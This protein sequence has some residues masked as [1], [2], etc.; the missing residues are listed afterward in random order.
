MLCTVCILTAEYILQG[1]PKKSKH[2][3]ESSLDCVKNHSDDRFFVNF[4]NKTSTTILYVCIKYSVCDLICDVIGCCVWS[5]NAAKINANDKL[6]SSDLQ[7]EI[8]ENM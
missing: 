1:G 8:K 2:Y 3:Q 4:D 6:V 5:C 7:Q